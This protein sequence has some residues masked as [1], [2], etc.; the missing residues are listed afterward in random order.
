MKYVMERCCI[1]LCGLFIVSLLGA[2]GG[3]QP[4][5]EAPQPPPEEPAEEPFEEPEPMEEPAQYQPPPEEP[6]EEP[7]TPIRTN[8]R[9]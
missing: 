1:W 6:A 5:P 7:D 9:G 2:C 4:E 8:G 3:A